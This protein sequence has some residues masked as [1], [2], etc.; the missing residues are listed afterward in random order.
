MSQEVRRSFPG[1]TSKGTS[2]VPSGPRQQGTTGED[3]PAS[4]AAVVLLRSSE[5]S[6][7]RNVWGWT[8]TAMCI[9]KVIYGKRKCRVVQYFRPPHALSFQL[10]P[11]GQSA[12][13]QCGVSTQKNP[14][15]YCPTSVARVTVHATPRDGAPH[16]LFAILRFR[17]AS[18]S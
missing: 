13:A 18:M 11:V 7:D 17:V 1:T 15:K 4:K 9:Y 14:S 12:A 2:K 10:D 6:K 5:H 16:F 3:I 8:L